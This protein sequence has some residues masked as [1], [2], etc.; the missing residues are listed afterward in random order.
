MLQRPNQPILRGIRLALFLGYGGLLG[1]LAL[2]GV[3]SAQTL[4][5][6][7]TKNTQSSGIY[8]E[9]SDHLEAILSRAYSAS[10]LVR[11]YLIDPDADAT[12]QHRTNARGA[13]VQTLAALAE[14]RRRAA[15]S[16][17]AEIAQLEHDMT[18]YWATAERGLQL[19]GPRRIQDG[20]EILTSQLA[21]QRDQWLATLNGLRLLD[22]RDLHNS[23]EE[24]TGELAALRR[25]LWLAV[26]FSVL[27]GAALTAVTWRHLMRLEGEARQQYNA[28]LEFAGR[29]EELS[30]RVLGI[31]EDERRKLARELH[32]EV[33]QILS[34]LL[35]DLGQAQG[36]LAL[37]PAEA[38]ERLHS[39]HH[40]AEMALN[41]VRNMTLLLR[42]SML[43]DLGLVPALYWQARETSRRT[44]MDVRV[45]TEHEDLD[46]PDAVRTT[47]YRVVQ[48][49]LQNASRHSRAGN[50]EIV[51]Q[52][53]EGRLRIL[54]RDDG[55][56]FDPLRTKGIGLLGMQERVSQLGGDFDVESAP[57][58]GT[59]LR[60]QLPLE[61]GE[62]Q[63]TY[64][65]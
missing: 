13:W 21:P 8:I 31:Q 41:T 11:D 15:D 42:P 28:S 60:V 58:R 56:G 44:G 55:R 9:R 40:L 17:T 32:D 4:S 38:G 5:Y 54:V 7:Q 14:Y 22:Q 2:L 53:V 47:I 3:F 45:I 65:R 59:I 10:A 39:A 27:L 30:Q 62:K 6:V 26:A 16:R 64:S 37:A 50:V 33:G 51:L 63:E 34:A 35:V 43:D 23:I 1:L 57:G 25:K 19:T 49:A 48:E 18:R 61:A 36:S 12:D 29:L 20:Y 24:A 52:L 46:L